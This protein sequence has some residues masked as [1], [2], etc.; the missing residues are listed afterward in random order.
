MS[1]LIFLLV[2]RA[3]WQCCL[4]GRRLNQEK[5]WLAQIDS[6]L[7]ATPR[8]DTSEA[9]IALDVWLEKTPEAGDSVVML[10]LEQILVGEEG[11]DASAVREWIHWSRYL[12]GVFVF[13]GLL[14]TV[15][16]MSL[17]L[18]KLGLTI[19]DTSGATDTAMTSQTGARLL[20]GIT[21]LLSG[22]E[23]AFL[24]TLAGILATLLIS[25]ANWRY[26]YACDQFE[27]AFQWMILRRLSRRPE[28]DALSAAAKS[29]ADVSG[30]AFHLSAKL[31]EVSTQFEK[32]IG[33]L[34][35]T[36]DKAGKVIAKV[37]GIPVERYE[38]LSRSSEALAEVARLLK[39][40]R[41]SQGEGS[42]TVQGAATRMERAVS[43]LRE[44]LSES[45]KTSAE[46]LGKMV[47]QVQTTNASLGETV[48]RFELALNDVTA[49]VEAT[50]MRQEM[51]ALRAALAGG[52]PNTAAQQS[53]VPTNGRFTSPI[54]PEVHP[55]Q[56]VMRPPM[57]ISER[58]VPASPPPPD[59]GWQ[60]VRDW[61]SE[62]ADRFKR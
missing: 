54:S 38:D 25:W 32:E 28:A 2:L 10:S 30:S 13:I 8:M 26:L 55:P 29:L 34:S 24:C 6:A 4:A 62:T 35:A 18:G 52:R 56:L 5:E 59:S 27:Q 57:N 45:Q 3:W 14:G 21:G 39:E 53:P 12:A 17:A 47:S 31:L 36:Y 22:M 49:V 15:F 61:M 33:S 37:E 40:E 11:V 41:H 16:S 58:P 7:K 44:N 48:R 1:V 51:A 50:P 19:S 46:S 43:D 60:R 23:S 20:T 9:R 42:D